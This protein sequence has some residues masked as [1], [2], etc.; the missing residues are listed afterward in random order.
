MKKLTHR[1]KIVISIFVAA[2]TFILFSVLAF[3]F[4][5]KS[6]VD[7]G[8]SWHN[9]LV[10]LVE[11]DGREKEVFEKLEKSDSFITS[12]TEI[13]SPYNT[14]VSYTN[15]NNLES[16]T[17]DEISSRFH[18][19]DPRYDQ[20]MQSVP[21]YFSGKLGGKECTVFYFGKKEGYSFSSVNNAVIEILG[22]PKSVYNWIIPVGGA[23]YFKPAAAILYVLM[24]AVFIFIDRK[25]R[26]KVIFIFLQ[27]I[28]WI[29]LLFVNGNAVFF[30]AVASLFL[31]RAVLQFEK[32]VLKIYVYID[33]FVA[34]KCL[35]EQQSKIVICFSIYI[36]LSL[37]SV[38]APFFSF[39]DKV[40]AVLALLCAI[41]FEICL[42]MGK[43]LLIFYRTTNYYHRPFF[44]I[45]IKKNKSLKYYEK[46]KK[47]PLIT[48]LIFA[49]LFAPLYASGNTTSFLQGL[50][51]NDTEIASF[52][53][54]E[55]TFHFPKSGIS[56]EFL[57][58]IASS[59][60]IKDSRLS[61]FWDFFGH[62]AYQISLPHLSVSS[63]PESSTYMNF[64]HYYLEKNNHGLREIG[65]NLFTEKWLIDSIEAYKNSGI[66][67]LLLDRNRFILAT[68][69]N[70]DSTVPVWTSFFSFLFFLLLLNGAER[71]K[72]GVSSGVKKI[73]PFYRRRKEKAA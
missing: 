54:P 23:N 2:F 32:E 21:S 39:A 9:Y 30:P 34:L 33:K 45:P 65:L 37:F 49:A 63:I 38:T 66:T 6:G 43:F 51:L 52:P 18:S 25:A 50:S 5:S 70:L 4:L 69:G 55:Q 3:C 13:I 24:V 14:F 67:R 61:P 12:V 10:F 48:V 35:K 11:K 22:E 29:F 26:D 19:T 17:V 42:I 27:A 64:S 56:P 20:F 41:V 68:V 73:I 46:I 36:I 47:I 62:I 7:Q 15:Y 1:K 40:S 72:K 60:Q 57:E 8:G 44:V 71:F 28:P 53:I 16:V 59:V 58:T 31:L